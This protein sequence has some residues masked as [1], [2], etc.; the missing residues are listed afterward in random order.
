MAYYSYCSCAI[1][2]PICT[3]VFKCNSLCNNYGTQLDFGQILNNNRLITKDY[4]NI[5]QGLTVDCQNQQ[6]IKQD[7]EQPL[8]FRKV[9]FFKSSIGF[10]ATDVNLEYLNWNTIAEETNAVPK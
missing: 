7:F 3:R 1:I 5:I 8:K 4:V 6:P 9:M 2:V 10:T